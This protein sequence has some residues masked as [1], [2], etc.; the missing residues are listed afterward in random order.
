MILQFSLS[1]IDLE[2][3]DSTFTE[4]LINTKKN[5]EKLDPKNISILNFKNLIE[6]ISNVEIDKFT[7]I[8]S[9]LTSIIIDI[10]RIQNLSLVFFGFID[11]HE[12]AMM[13]SLITLEISNKFK[14]INL[15]VFFEALQQVNAEM[16]IFNKYSKQEFYIL[17][18]IVLF[19]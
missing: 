12:S 11:P 18:N 14:N 3:F 9:I 16:S 13:E 5:N 2:G 10:L 17:E 6:A 7:E 1:F 19:K 15:D 4:I 8:N